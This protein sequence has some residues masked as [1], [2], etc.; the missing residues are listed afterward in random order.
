MKMTKRL[1]TL[2][3]CAVMGASS[4]VGMGAFAAGNASIASSNSTHSQNNDTGYRMT[5]KLLYQSDSEWGSTVLGTNSSGGTATIKSDGCA[6][7]C[8]SM[9]LRYY[10][11]SNA[12]PKTVYNKM[13]SSA[14][15]S[16]DF[17]GAANTF[18]SN[19]VSLSN[20]RTNYKDASNNC[21]NIYFENDTLQQA[22][23]RSRLYAAI[24]SGKPVIVGVAKSS[25]KEADHFVVAT[26]VSTGNAV[27]YINDPRG[28][29]SSYATLNQYFNDNYHIAR[30]IIYS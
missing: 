26:G 16:F 30:L 24:R 10:G 7:T 8:F 11:L 15:P 27:T 29:N 17:Y 1:A 13:S 23:A 20:S 12:T 18:Y 6:I 2:A 21:D 4:M 9:I 22:N 3:A 19:Y 28:A 25:S 14:F 5:L